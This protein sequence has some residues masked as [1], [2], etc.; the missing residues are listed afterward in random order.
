MVYGKQSIKTM[1]CFL[2]FQVPSL[3]EG[4]TMSVL[5]VKGIS[6]EEIQNMT[7]EFKRHIDSPEGK[8]LLEK[9]VKNAKKMK[10]RLD[11]ARRIDPKTLHE[12]F[13]I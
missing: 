13:T 12:P 9:A 8:R 7:E 5:T 1:L 10:A 3:K 6:K 11:K 4:H 2:F